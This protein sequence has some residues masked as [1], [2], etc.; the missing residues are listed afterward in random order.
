PPS[1]LSVLSVCFH[2]LGRLQPG[3]ARGAAD[4]PHR[5]WP[6]G[7]YHQTPAGGTDANA[8]TAGGAAAPD[9]SS[10][11]AATVPVGTSGLGCADS[12]FAVQASLPQRSILRCANGP[13]FCRL[14]V[15][16]HARLSHGG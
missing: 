6:L 5:R 16:G 13:V 8:A 7:R 2:L 11:T 3:R 9:P 1:V 14:A 4:A 10:G 12:D 15:L